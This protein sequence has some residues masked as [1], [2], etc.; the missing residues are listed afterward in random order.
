MSHSESASK[1]RSRSNASRRS[2]PYLATNPEDL[3]LPEGNVTE[4]QVG[5]L[6]EFIHP[7]RHTNTT[8]STAVDGVESYIE[9]DEDEDSEHSF[10]SRPWY[11]RPSPLWYVFYLLE[12]TS[13]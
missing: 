12:A 11:R 4:E 10:K 2:F 1:S 9:N 7:R 3:L 5:L 6:Q 13:V 8:E